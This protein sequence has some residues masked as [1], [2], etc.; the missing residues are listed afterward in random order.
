MGLEFEQNETNENSKEEQILN[1]IVRFRD[2]IREN[3]KSDP[4]KIL[5]ICDKFRDYDMVDLSIRLEDKKIGDPS[6]WKYESR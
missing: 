1:A 4:K 6:V 2:Q 5:E 3:S